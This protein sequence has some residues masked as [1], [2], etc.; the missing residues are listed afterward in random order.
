MK[1]FCPQHT[2]PKNI[3]VHADLLSFLSYISGFDTPS[4][5]NQ[6]LT[7]SHPGGGI[8]GGVTDTLGKGVSG[9]CYLNQCLVESYTDRFLGVTDTAGNLVGGKYSPD[10]MA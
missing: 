8:L 5:Y 3:S 9:K 7:A 6:S 1:L 2:R 10:K 4:Q